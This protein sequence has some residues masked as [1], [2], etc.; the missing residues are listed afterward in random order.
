[1]AVLEADLEH[2]LRH[3]GIPLPPDGFAEPFDAGTGFANRVDP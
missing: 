3:G 1:V 2:A